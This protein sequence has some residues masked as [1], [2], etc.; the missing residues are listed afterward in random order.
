MS[1]VETHPTFD[2]TPRK[3]AVLALFAALTL[4][5]L[6]LLLP[7]LAGLEDTWHRIQHGDP[8]WLILAG[9]FTL[10]MF[11]GYVLQFHA[12]YQAG[13][14]WRE[15]LQVTMAALAASRIFSA[16]GA[17]GLVLQ[18]WALRRAGLDAR[19]VADRT[20]GFIVLQYLVYTMAVFLFGLALYYGLL[21]GDAPFAITLLPA[22]LALAVTALGLSLGFVPP[23]LQK[24]LSAGRWKR[25]AQVP[26]SA[27]AG[28][29]I[30]LSR[31]RRP[32]LAVAGAFGFWAFQIGVLWAAFEAFGEAPPVAVLIVGFFVGML[33]NLLPLPGGIG[34]VDG[35]MIGAFAA[36]GIESG[37]ALVAVLTFRGFTFWLPTIPGFIAFVALR[38]TVGTWRNDQT[39]T[40]T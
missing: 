1:N 11:G 20:V 22:I 6:Y 26:A 3:L 40:Y 39:P 28:I 32:D 17:G 5:A 7:Q 2:V 14:T 4:V 29:R 37:L 31:L 13:L 15:S 18:S 16:G 12:T 25:L 33:G 30:A 38:R 36:L 27:S 9:V 24:R 21:P 34:G 8:A 19:T 23:D 10:G 35:G